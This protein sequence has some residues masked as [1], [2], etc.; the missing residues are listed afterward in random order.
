MEITLREATPQDA[1]AILALI[2]TLNEETSFVLINSQAIN[3]SVATMAGEIE[4][5][6]ELKNQLLL[7]ATTEDSVVGLATVTTDTD[8]AIAHIGEIGLS[9]LKDYWGL[10]LGTTMLKEL[11]L[12]S[13]TST[14]LIRLDIKVQSHN[15]RAIALYNKVGFSYEGTLRRAVLTKDNTFADVD[16]M[17]Y[18]LDD[19]LAPKNEASD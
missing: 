10:G 4:A 6:S 1:S 19:D 9:L 5:I 18:L 8:P 17:G 16:M 7:L 12:W 11:I 3:M 2:E 13:R 15:E 14:D